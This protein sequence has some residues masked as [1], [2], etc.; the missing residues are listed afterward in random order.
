MKQRKKKIKGYR[1]LYRMADGRIW[2]D[3]R[4]TINRKEVKRTK[5]AKSRLAVEAVAERAELRQEA[6][7]ELDPNNRA[8]AERD[9]T[10]LAYAK[11]WLERKT[12]R[13]EILA[14]TAYK[15]AADLENYLLPSLADIPV[16]ELTKRHVEG[17]KTSLCQSGLAPS[18]INSALR[19]LKTMIADAVE[20]LELERNPV[21]RILALRETPSIRRSLPPEELKELLTFTRNVESEWYPAILLVA[22]TGIRTSEW[23]AL[24]WDCL[25]LDESFLWIRQVADRNGE[26]RLGTKSGLIRKAPLLP[27][28]IEQLDCHLRRLEAQHHPGL[29]SGLMFPSPRFSKNTGWL[30]SITALRGKLKSICQR[31]LLPDYTP[32]ELRHTFI[33]RAREN[34]VDR[35]DLKAIVGHS[36]DQMIEH[37]SHVS[38]ETRRRAVMKTFSDGVIPVSGVSETDTWTDTR[39]EQKSVSGE[40]KADLPGV[41][42]RHHMERDTRLELATYS[43]GSCHSRNTK[44]YRVK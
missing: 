39:P 33:T 29:D 22:T 28:V 24:T 40:R 5:I 17:T 16:G 14:S 2:I 12:I 38:P 25:N 41:S 37:Y 15:Y 13:N 19:L 8:S 1:G 42:R 23:R 7:R 27:E 43:L 36:T 21:K 44:L 9:P 3:V 18:T 34:G 4:M 30:Y 20:E 11:S 10:I 31:A 35:E 6:I 32:H 26:V